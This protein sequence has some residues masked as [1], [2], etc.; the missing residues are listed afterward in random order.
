MSDKPEFVWAPSV[1]DGAI[2]SIV[3]WRD[4][5]VI[6]CQYA[7]YMT[8]L[9]TMRKIECVLTSEEAG[10]VGKPEPYQAHAAWA[11]PVE[12]KRVAN[13]RMAAEV[14]NRAFSKAKEEAG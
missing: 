9:E 14:F 13:S 2:V 3:Q 6:A 8:D 10:E 11:A 7:V 1:E 12:K 4:E 5:I